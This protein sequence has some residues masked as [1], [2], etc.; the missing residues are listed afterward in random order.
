MYGESQSWEELS[1][2]HSRNVC[3][4]DQLTWPRDYMGA[5]LC[6]ETALLIFYPST[7]RER[8]LEDEIAFYIH[9]K[10]MPQPSDKSKNNCLLSGQAAT[11][12]EALIKRCFQLWQMEH[13]ILW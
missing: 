1:N 8:Y 2:L 12:A 10:V 6:Q 7:C 11:E 9:L 5:G 4:T 3:P 13:H